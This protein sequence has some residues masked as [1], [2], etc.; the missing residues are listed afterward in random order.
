[1]TISRNIIAAACAVVV[2]VA[3]AWGV[4]VNNRSATGEA[5][6]TGQSAAGDSAV[7]VVTAPVRSERLTTQ[8][9]ALGTARANEAVEI[10]SKASNLVTAVRFKDGESVRAGQ[11]LVELDSAQARAD[12]AEAEAPHGKH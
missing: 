10:T 7:A 9:N 4:T 2:L 3:V 12:V 1:M 6:P 8:L 11:V 5:S